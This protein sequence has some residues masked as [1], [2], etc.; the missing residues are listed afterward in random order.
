MSEASMNLMNVCPFCQ[1]H[2]LMPSGH[3]HGGGLISNYHECEGQRRFRE[4]YKAWRRRQESPNP[5][6]PERRE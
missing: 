4:G 2:F 1:T 6:W 3:T 5:T